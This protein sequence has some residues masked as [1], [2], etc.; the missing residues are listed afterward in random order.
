MHKKNAEKR[1][2]FEK[3][4][5]FDFVNGDEQITLNVGGQKFQT[6]AGV[7]CRDRFSL[8]ASICK[9]DPP[10]S[11]DEDGAF[12]FERDWWIFRYVLQF[13]RTRDLPRDHALLQE[14]YGEAAFYRLNSLRRAIQRRAAT[15]TAITGS[16]MSS[17]PGGT[18]PPAQGANAASARTRPQNQPTRVR[19]LYR[20]PLADPFGFSGIKDR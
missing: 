6:T 3:E 16:A 1:E 8:L 14:M 19:G 11:K 10:F 13:L 17:G 2:A 12:F 7:L 18:R 15:T 5:A 20:E 4:S 9:T